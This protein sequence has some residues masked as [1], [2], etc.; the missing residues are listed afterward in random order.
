M[1]SLL[2]RLANL[3]FSNIR[4]PVFPL[5]PVFPASAG[6]RGGSERADRGGV[7]VRLQRD[8]VA[9]RGRPGPARAR[10]LPHAQPQLCA[11]HRERLLTGRG[12]GR[13]QC[14][15]GQQEEQ[16]SPAHHHH[17]RQDHPEQHR[18]V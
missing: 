13:R 12:G 5:L 17:H 3:A 14:E 15:G 1:R 9:G 7:R 11:R 2:V 18:S 10:L 16:L 6:E 8:G 4:A